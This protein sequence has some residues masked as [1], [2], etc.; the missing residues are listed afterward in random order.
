[1]CGGGH[2]SHLLTDNES[3]AR[4]S[5]E[6]LAHHDIPNMGIWGSEVDHQTNT[7]DCDRDTEVEGEPLKATSVSNQET[8]DE[9]P[10][11]G[12]NAVDVTHITCL[13]D[14]QVINYLEERAE[15]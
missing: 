7:Q 1:M 8:D 11:T 5:D 15:N 9:R 2:S 12:A 3:A 13:G 10:E 14:V 4:D 6:N